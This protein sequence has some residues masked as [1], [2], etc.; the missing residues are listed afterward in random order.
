MKR[1]GLLAI[2]FVFVITACGQ[3]GPLYLP[4]PAPAATSASS[5]AAHPA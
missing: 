1:C 5:P 4:K 3:A 2:F